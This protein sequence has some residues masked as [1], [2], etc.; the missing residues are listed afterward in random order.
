M[1]LESNIN[2]YARA[3]YEIAIEKKQL[4]VFHSDLSA[5]IVAFEQDNR[6]HSIYQT[7]A[8]D[9]GIKKQFIIQIFDRS[10]APDILHL[11]LYLIDRQHERLITRIINRTLSFINAELQIFHAR[12]YTPFELNQTQINAI[13]QKIKDLTNKNL[14]STVIIKPNLI[15]GIRVEYGDYILDNSIRAKLKSLR[16]EI[17]KGI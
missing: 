5:L 9:K 12:I 4:K 8:I 2:E 3:M 16:R 1:I 7:L 13:N 10:I 15:G 17:K 11:M 14:T 6:F